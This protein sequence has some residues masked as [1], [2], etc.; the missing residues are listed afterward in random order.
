MKS[1]VFVFAVVIAITS[2]KQPK[3]ESGPDAAAKDSVVETHRTTPTPS[4][5]VVPDNGLYEKKHAN[6]NISIT[7]EM[8]DGKREGLWK[9]FYE[10]GT[11]WSEG[12]YKNGLRHG[13]SITWFEN[14]KVRYEGT[15]TNGEQSGKWKYYNENGQLDKEV[16]H[17]KHTSK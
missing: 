3:Q 5:T 9:S 8:R 7:G 17:D 16:D 13:R 6:G 11:P 1:F 12:E 14:G 15:Y 4:D 10:N 2:C